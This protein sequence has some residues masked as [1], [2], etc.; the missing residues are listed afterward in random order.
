ML[1]VS[2]LLALG[3][4]FQSAAA[5]QPAVS[6]GELRQ[7]ATPQSIGFEWDV[8]GDDD[9]DAIVNVRYRP[10]GTV[11]WFEAFP[12]FRVDFNG[13]N[14]LAGSILF[15][16]GGTEYEVELDLVDPDGG[17]ELRT[18]TITTPAIPAMPEGG[19]TFF[20]TPGSG[21]GDGSEGDP[22]QGLEAAQAVAQP[23]DIFMVGPGDYRGSRVIFGT[24]GNEGNYIVWLGDPDS[25]PLLDDVRLASY[26]WLEGFD[27]SA[28]TN[29]IRHQG[30]SFGAVVKGNR[31]TGCDYCIHLGEQAEGWWIS[32]NV[33]IGINDPASGSFGGEGVELSHSDFG[34]MGIFAEVVSMIRPHDDDG[35]FG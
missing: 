28:D 1:R 26:V 27:L 25:P 23:G 29:V 17:D 2:C 18:A 3:V 31:I 24:P 22:F 35:I 11:D 21:G 33:I 30:E 7:Y 19:R 20:V 32:D 9:H 16:A 13:N 8:T 14:M 34:P 12:M 10:S 5:A 15:V 6:A 4:V